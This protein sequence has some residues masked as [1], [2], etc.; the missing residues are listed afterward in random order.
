MQGTIEND[1]L[2][3]RS[4]QNT[5]DEINQN[6]ISIQYS[7]N[8]QN[9]LIQK[10]VSIQGSINPMNK[11]N[12]ISIQQDTINYIDQSGQYSQYLQS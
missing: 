10:D 3:D 7:N 4:M 6:D 9:R 2:I 8:G 5:I 1:R 12:D 11:G